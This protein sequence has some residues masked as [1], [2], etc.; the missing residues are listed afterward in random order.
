M[1]EKRKKKMVM[2]QFRNQLS[3]L[4]SRKTIYLQLILVNNSFVC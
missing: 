2:D 4:F 3:Q 1:Y